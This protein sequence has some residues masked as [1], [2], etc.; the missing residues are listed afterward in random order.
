MDFTEDAGVPRHSLREGHFLGSA[1]VC[2]LQEA[3]TVP[4]GECT[5]PLTTTADTGGGLWQDNDRWPL[6][7]FVLMFSV[8][9]PAF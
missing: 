6:M 9:N 4:G 7:R 3:P 8:L 2:K 5:R 1:V